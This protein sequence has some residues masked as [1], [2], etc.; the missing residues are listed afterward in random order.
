LSP[1]PGTGVGDETWT[2]ILGSLVALVCLT[3]PNRRDRG[4]S[5]RVMR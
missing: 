2:G 1:T 4:A 5:A 3:F